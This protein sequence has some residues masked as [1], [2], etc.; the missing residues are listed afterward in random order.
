MDEGV[1]LLRLSSRVSGVLPT[2]FLGLLCTG[3]VSGQETEEE[4]GMASLLRFIEIGGIVEVTASRNQKS[5]GESSTSTAA[6]QLE[7]GIG[8]EPHEWIGSEFGWIHEHEAH[9]T[10]HGGPPAGGIE[11]LPGWSLATAIHYGGVAFAAECMISQDRLDP[12]VLE[13]AGQGARPAS[14]TLEA[15]YGFELAGRGGAHLH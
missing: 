1:Y 11:R 12:G 7:L 10:G 6:E 15:G 14:W 5:E 2:V 9:G 13:F 8:I 3:A 4:T